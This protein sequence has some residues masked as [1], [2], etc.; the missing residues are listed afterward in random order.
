MHHI[1][2]PAGQAGPHL[3]VG[4]HIG[5]GE[6]DI[7]LPGQPLVVS[8]VDRLVQRVGGQSVYPASEIIRL[9]VQPHHLI[10]DGLVKLALGFAG[11]LPAKHADNILLNLAGPFVYTGNSNVPFNFFYFIL[12][13]VAVTAQG[14]DGIFGC[15][16][17]GFRGE[18]LGNRTFHF[19]IFFPGIQSFS[20]L[21]NES[22]RGGQPDY[23]RNDQ[24]VGVP[25]LFRQ[26]GLELNAF[27]GIIN[28]NFHGRFP[29]A[30]GHGG[31]YQSRIPEDFTGMFES[32]AGNAADQIFHRHEGIGKGQ[33]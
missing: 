10:P 1:K 19:K 29:A 21:L 6:H 2:G 5:Q 18:Q 13:N 17:G 7:L 24:F 27:L 12:G 23:M 20:G 25:L 4:H 16:V 14:L 9:T 22:L 15:F 11:F 26:R 33:R 32:L 30:Q 28:G 31:N 3:D 8:Q